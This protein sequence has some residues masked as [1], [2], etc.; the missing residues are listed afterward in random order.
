[1][2]MP[3]ASRW[4]RWT[5]W[6]RTLLYLWRTRHARRRMRD[7][8]YRRRIRAEIAA[9]PEVDRLAREARLRMMARRQPCGLTASALS[10][11]AICRRPHGHQGA[12]CHHPDGAVA[13]PMGF[14][15]WR[16]CVRCAAYWMDLNPLHEAAPPWRRDTVTV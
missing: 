3:T 4:V 6:A 2:M 9:D 11:A 16:F 13:P 8:E 12:H 10:P 14:S 5:M 1:M 15:T 7:P